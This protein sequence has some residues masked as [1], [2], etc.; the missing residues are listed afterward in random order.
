MYCVL[1]QNLHELA[2]YISVW[3]WFSS[4]LE[5]SLTPAEHGINK[6]QFVP[7]EKQLPN[8]NM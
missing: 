3:N 6:I 4:S 5:K 7:L 2:D 8:R 1:Q